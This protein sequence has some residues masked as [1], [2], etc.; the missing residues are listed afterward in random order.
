MSCTVRENRPCLRSRSRRR[1]AC[2]EQSAFLSSALI[3]AA[4]C[5]LLPAARRSSL[6]RGR[7]RGRASSEAADCRRQGG[8]GDSATLTLFTRLCLSRQPPSTHAHVAPS[9]LAAGARRDRGRRA[10]DCGC[11]CSIAAEASSHVPLTARCLAQCIVG[12]ITTAA[13]PCCSVH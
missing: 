1:R 7:S 2:C 13:Y 5:L 9:E 3:S 11:V 10:R 6:L 12:A 8:D 4:P